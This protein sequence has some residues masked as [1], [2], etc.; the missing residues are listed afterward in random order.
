M[1][2]AHAYVFS[3]ESFAWEGLDHDRVR[4]SR[5]R[6]TPSRPRTRSSTRGDVRAILGRGLIE[7][8]AA[9]AADF[10]RVDGSPGR[11]DR[12]ARPGRGAADAPGDRVVLQVSRWDP[13][14]D[15]IGVIRRLRAS[16]SRRDDRRAPRLA[17]P[18][19]GGRGRRPRGPAVFASAIADLRG[20]ARA[21]ARA[22]P[23]RL[24]ADG[25]PRGE[26]RDRQRAAAPRDGGGAEEPRR[27]VRPDGDR[28]DVEGPAGRGVA[29]RRHP[30]P[31]RSTA[32]AGCCVD[33]PRDLAAFGAAVARLLAD[34]ALA[35]RLG[36]AAHERVR[37]EFLA[38]RHLAQ[39]VRL[40]EQVVSR[41]PSRA[42]FRA[43]HS[44]SHR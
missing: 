3:R 41:R 4:S 39:Y 18:A 33:D 11:V 29:H 14:K 12:A 17:G 35:R 26:R 27:G 9:A 25:R 43:D 15:P 6:S 19:V 23:P 30:G 34:P 10:A 37:D 2:E 1:R 36:E 13:L 8:G 38:P 32:R 44:R 21:G 31:D 20:A 28:G 22:R 7:D 42:G 24:A 16:T 5:R 40:I